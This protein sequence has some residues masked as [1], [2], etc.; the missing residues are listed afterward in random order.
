MAGDSTMEKWVHEEKKFKGFPLFLTSKN[1]K[2]A[3]IG[4]L[5]MW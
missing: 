2:T 1:L 3:S 4:G 5:K